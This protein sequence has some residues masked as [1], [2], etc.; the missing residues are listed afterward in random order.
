MPPFPGKRSDRLPVRVSLMYAAVAAVWILFSDTFLLWLGLDVDGQVAV[1]VGK[2]LAFVGVT[3]ALLYLILSR[4]TAEKQRAQEDLDRAEQRYRGQ[5]D[6]LSHGVVEVDQRGRVVFA[7]REAEALLG[8]AAEEL[9]GA[10][11][12]DWLQGTEAHRC[13]GRALRA[14]VTNDVDSKGM[15]LARAGQQP[16]G[17][18]V[19]LQFRWRFLDVGDTV[20]L[21]FE[22]TDVSEWQQ[23]AAESRRLTAVLEATTDM[24][25]T[26]DRKGRLSY[27]N[28]AGERVLGVSAGDGPE[29]ANIRAR[30]PGWAQL[31][32]D[33]RAMPAALQ[34]GDWAGESGMLDADDREF[35]VSQAL[36]AHRNE[37]GRLESFS[38]I[39]RDISEWK[40]RDAALYAAREQYRSLV[41]NTHDGIAVAQQGRVC[42]VN[43]RL[44]AL[45]GFD[46]REYIGH[47]S[48]DFV[49]PEDRERVRHW[50]RAIRDSAPRDECITFRFLT[51]N[52]DVR[53]MKARASIVLWEGDRAVLSFFEDVTER[54]RA[55]DRLEY[56]AEFDALTGLPNRDLFLSRLE[57]TVSDGGQRNPLAVVYLNLTRFQIFNDSYGHALGDRLLRAVSERLADALGDEDI[58]A[59]IGG[60]EFVVLLTGLGDTDAIPQGVRSIIGALRDPLVLDGQEFFVN[61]SA[62]IAVYPDD[63]DDAQVLL[64]NAASALETAKQSG[65]GAYRYYAAG[66]NEQARRR[67]ALETDLRHALSRGEFEVYFQPQV[68]LSDGM[69]KGSEALLRW[70]HSEQGMIMPGDFIPLLEESELILDV[71]AWVL[72]RACEMQ[73]Y[74]ERQHGSRV[75][76]SVNL[77]PRQLEDDALLQRVGA[78]LDETLASPECVELEITESSLVH[79]P[80]QAART[81]E[82]LKALGLSIAVDD[83]GTGYSSLSYFRRFPV[84]TIKIDKA[85]VAEATSDPDTAEIIRAIIAMGHSLGCQLIAE[86]VETLG[87]LRFLRRAGC[88]WMQGYYLA[89]PLPSAEFEGLVKENGPLARV[90]GADDRGPVVL[91]V[92][93]NPGLPRKVAAALPDDAPA[94]IVVTTA[95]EAFEEMASRELAAVVVHQAPKGMDP[96]PFLYRTRLLYPGVRRL[97]IGD[98]GDVLLAAQVGEAAPV[99]ELL[100]HPLGQ[101]AVDRAVERA[102]R[103]WR[104]PKAVPLRR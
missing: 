17:A 7:N 87:E 94:P 81:L 46:G 41:E 100:T 75:R 16:R 31:V 71:G 40:A 99:Q 13:M 49:H 45:L 88:D 84:D 74:W 83:F 29:S 61:A 93:R 86:G 97:L 23:T 57:Q 8:A 25:G 2:G 37:Q 32:L 10:E 80:A 85:F 90:A 14:A 52:G 102:V 20:H 12:G 104:A 38:F 73:R 39:L 1:S 28:R 11:L 34:K 22:F 96:L 60:D 44:S 101:D 65:P 6:A 51:V 42:Y 82:A 43:P 15:F 89:R 64:R 79:N 67:L 19:D 91:V 76:V 5:V 58:V 24:V 66:L 72:R 78:I 36:I 33:E 27:L 35:P 95:A 69:L 4:V 30:M 26:M 68:A 70:N 103:S 77:S 55:E 56:L 18:P 48:M 62:G 92:G 47:R 21:L 3:A 50:Y 59:R 98:A 63:S 54:V 9:E 53:H